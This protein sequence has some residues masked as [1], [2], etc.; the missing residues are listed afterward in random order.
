MEQLLISARKA[1]DYIVIEIAPI[2]SVVG[3]KMIEHFIDRFVFVVEWGRPSEVLSQTRFP[4]GRSFASASQASSSTR[5]I[6]SH[7]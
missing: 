5:P 4:K 7:Y 6:L 1:Y 2:M 3:I